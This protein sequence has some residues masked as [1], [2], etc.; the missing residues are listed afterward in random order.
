MAHAV[1]LIVDEDALLRWSL[2]ERL[3]GDGY[4][5]FEAATSAAALERL[6]EGVDVMLIDVSLRDAVEPAVLK[7]VRQPYRNT[8]VILM[9]AHLR[10]DDAAEKIEPG[11]FQIVEK[12]FD[13]DQVAVLV[14]KMLAASRLRREAADVRRSAGPEHR[15][16]ANS[17]AVLAANRL[18]ARALRMLEDRRWPGDMG[19]LRRV[20]LR[21][22]FLMGG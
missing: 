14:G 17:P 21:A 19:D 22:M 11:A 9:T 6:R 20:I 1:V 8:P 4:E 15:A 5:V 18:L 12:P 7:Y 3:A 13:V 16:D 2:K 10:F